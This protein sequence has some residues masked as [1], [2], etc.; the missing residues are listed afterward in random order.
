MDESVH[1]LIRQFQ[2]KEQS[3]SPMTSY[4]L[5]VRKKVAKERFADLSITLAKLYGKAKRRTYTVS[6]YN[7][8]TRVV[9]GHD[10]RQPFKKREQKTV[11]KR[12]FFENFKVVLSEEKELFQSSSQKKE[13]QKPKR[14]EN[15][16]QIV[17][18]PNVFDGFELQEQMLE[19]LVWRRVAKSK[20]IY[21]NE[22][23]MVQ[24]RMLPFAALTWTPDREP[25]PESSL[26]AT[27]T[28]TKDVC[29]QSFFAK[30]FRI[31]LSRSMLIFSAFSKPRISYELEVEL[32]PTPTRDQNSAQVFEQLK[33]LWDRL[34]KF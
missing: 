27:K 22:S 21:V 15:L 12:L 11:L 13:Y 33:L 16:S 3:T 23:L 29:R 4:E 25:E 28:A 31:D 17:L 9:V 2:A 30:Y 18:G 24:N 34:N 7:D 6:Y 10:G 5:E 19:S 26:L 1:E 8:Q 20:K 14:P 32:L